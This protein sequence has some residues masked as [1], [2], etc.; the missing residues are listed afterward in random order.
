M[1]AK[2]LEL[3]DKQMIL[4][5]YYIFYQ[6]DNFAAKYNAIFRLFYNHLKIKA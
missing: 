2:E 5:T 1:C 4:N 6:S 3:I